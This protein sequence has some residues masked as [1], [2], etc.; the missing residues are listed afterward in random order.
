MRSAKYGYD[1]QRIRK[2]LLPMA[3]GKECHL[4]GEVMR[5]G[6]E[7]DLDHTADGKAYRGMTHAACN[8]SDGARRQKAK[9]SREW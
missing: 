5:Q 3:V 9:H 1:H 7:L 8:R 4:C 6:Q 2:E